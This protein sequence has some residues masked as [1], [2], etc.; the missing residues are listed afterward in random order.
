[1]AG[2]WQSTGLLVEGTCRWRG[3]LSFIIGR[4]CVLQTLKADALYLSSRE[5]L[6]L[7]IFSSV[8]GKGKTNLGLKPEGSYGTFAG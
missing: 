5:S 7:G 8:A 6:S 3:G 1:M 2:L 4:G